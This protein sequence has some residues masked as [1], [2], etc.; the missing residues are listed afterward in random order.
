[1]RK[2]PRPPRKRTPIES[3]A[4]PKSPRSRANRNDRLKQQAAQERSSL[5]A[6][7]AEAEA[8]RGAAQSEA[9]RARLAA[10]QANLLRQQ[11]EQEKAA[12][13]EQ[14][15]Q[16]LNMILE[17]RSTARGLIVNMNDVLFDTAKYAASGR[18]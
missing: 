3:A 7:R 16:Q 4:K 17:T 1:M 14:L 11:S 6:A 13:K 10:D 5:E 12:L 18:A 2:P 8:A 15:R 9:E